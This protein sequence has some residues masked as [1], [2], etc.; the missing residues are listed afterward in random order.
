MAEATRPDDIQKI[1]DAE[2]PNP[3]GV[4]GF[5]RVL[6]VDGEVAVVRAFVPWAADLQVVGDDLSAA[7]PMKR[8]HG[9]G[10]FEAVFPHRD[11]FR[12]RL[13][14]TGADGAVHEIED[15]YALPSTLG[16]V[17]LHLLG[18]GRDLR[19]YHKFG[20]HPHELNGVAGV[21]FAVWAPNAERVSVVGEFNDWDGRRHP[22]RGHPGVGAWDLFIPGVQPGM[23][24]KYEIRPRGGPPFLK[25]DPVAF[26]SELRPATASVVHRI[27]GYAW[28]DEE[29]LDLRRQRDH[30]A[31]PM[32]VYEVH[33][34][35]WRWE[36]GRPLTYRELADRLP[37]YAGEMGF[38]HVELLPLMEHPYDPSWGY[39]VTGYFAPT[40]RFGEPDD[41]KLLVDRLH[42]RGIGVLLDWVPAHFPKDQTGLRRFDGT[43]L[44][45]HEDP[46]QGE[47][48]DWGTLIFNFGRNEVRNFLIS[49]ALF[50]I[51]EYHIDGL[52]V[53]AVASM[54]YLDYS[55]EAGEWL[56]N[57]YGGRENLEAIDFLRELN[58]TVRENQPGVLMIA[59]E[60]TAWP[61]VTQP[62]EHG[63][64][65]FHFKWNMGWMNDYLRFIEHEPVYRK[66]HFGMLTFS[67]MY[68]FS[69]AFILPLSH[70]EVVHG[71]R[72]MVDKMPGDA[73]QKFANLRLTLGYMWAHPGKQLLFMG[74]EIGQW[75]EWTEA[76][77][78]EWSLL[79]QPLHAGLQRWVRD[80]NHVYRREP[81]FWRRDASYE[82][83]DWIDFHDVEN[84]ILAFLRRGDPGDQDV[85]VVCNFT[86]VPR[87]GY[88][89]GVPAPGSY[90]ELLNSDSEIY[91]GSNVGNAGAVVAEPVASHGR[92]QSLWL[93]L[94]PMGVLVLRRDG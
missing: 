72:S 24:Y 37:D 67:L 77:P 40:S 5:H 39:Q 60:S 68:A 84:S 75:R 11:R 71:K 36:D 33:L 53:D 20:A 76:A 49:N 7:I 92:A 44:Y 70:D 47:H 21:R 4:L 45:E 14:A 79:E 15:P 46:R 65:G 86:P 78:L 59:E 9:D 8:V 31:E 6:L 62:V 56:P 18:E 88:R 54:L 94:P 25:S 42:Q 29:W 50:W 63:G 34:G 22:M 41:L 93:R 66:Y 51:D 43:A 73:W 61:G 64:L 38:T 28:G 27:G 16:D 83:F 32:S 80:L 74:A 91:G 10:F 85:V 1:I 82:G 48:P 2:H 30:A 35:S 13:R 89:I 26:R 12:Y 90:R 52:R 58:R 69:E 57:R 23:L 87:E 81:A 19:M 3:F 17:D 55:R